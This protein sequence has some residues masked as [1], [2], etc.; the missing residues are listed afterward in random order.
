MPQFVSLK[1]D[2]VHTKLLRSSSTYQLYV[3]KTNLAIFHHT[4]VF[5]SGSLMW[6]SLTYEIQNSK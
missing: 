2:D 6:N 4:F 3:S 1:L 5:T